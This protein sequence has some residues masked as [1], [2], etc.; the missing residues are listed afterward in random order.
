MSPALVTALLIYFWIN[1]SKNRKSV[2]EWPVKAEGITCDLKAQMEINV[3]YLKF[4]WYSIWKKTELYKQ[5]SQENKINK[6]G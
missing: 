2:M 1:P 6:T 3:Q 4:N 5:T